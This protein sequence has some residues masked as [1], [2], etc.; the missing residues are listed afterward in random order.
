MTT[1][2]RF[3][4]IVITRYFIRFSNSPA[5]IA[6]VE[7][8]NLKWLSDRFEIFRT[9]CLPSVVG[10][11]VLDFVWLLYF[12]V[13]TPDAELNHVRAL[14][15]AYPNIKIVICESFDDESRA[16]AIRDELSPDTQWLLTTRLDNDDGWHRDF[17]KTLHASLRFEKREFLNF[18]VGVLYFDHKTFLYRHLS[19]AFISLL[20]P[21][22]GFRTAWCAPHTQLDRIAPIRQLAPLPAFVQVVHPGTRSN[23]PRGVRVHRLLALA[24]FESVPGLWAG[25]EPGAE[26]DWD[27]ILYNITI[28]PIRV[29]RDGLRDLARR[30]TN[31]SPRPPT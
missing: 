8:P 23:K 22:Q 1:D 17:I 19:N 3:Q 28:V 12:D 7:S 26:S 6:A 27:I 2:R 14:I 5:D 24:G 30:I 16:R 21:V 25:H 20:E 9:F 18:P 10:Q 13:H 11:S 4:H 31:P 29:L 15:Q